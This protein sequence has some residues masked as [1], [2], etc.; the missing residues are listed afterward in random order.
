ML[1]VLGLGWITVHA[2]PLVRNGIV[3]IVND[4]IITFQELDGFTSQ[5]VAVLQRSFRNQPSVY[6]ERYAET[7][8]D[9]LDQ[10]IQRE[11]ILADF[12]KS[13]GTLNESYIDDEI[14]DRIR[15]QYGDRATLTK[16]LQQRG[17]TF[18]AFQTR[19]HKK[20]IIRFMRRM[21]V[22]SAIVVSP[23]K[24]ERYYTNH[25]GTFE[26][27]EQV[28]LRMLV[29]NRPSSAA[30]DPVRRRARQIRAKIEEGVPFAEMASVYSEG[31]ARQEGGNWD[32]VERSRLN[33]GLSEVAFGLEKGK[34]SPLLALAR[35]PNEDYWIYQ[36][37]ADG[38]LQ[39]GR[40][41]TGRDI[42]IEEK[43]F[44]GDEAPGEEALFPPQE[45]YLMLV[46]NRRE[47]RTRPLSEVREEIEK[48][49]EIEE[50]FRLE[51]KWIDKLAKQSFV[52]RY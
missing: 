36:Y 4:S 25:L 42:F 18:E 3:A 17:M 15:R 10:L 26:V 40:K 46:E 24:I 21:N 47:A 37:D 50:Q 29:L 39:K 2:Q 35:E 27:G 13:G 14:K 45:F 43:E 38:R 6:Q 19:T 22:S 16:T 51:K 28:K 52:I 12:E 48:E 5:A 49:L 23:A 34:V 8:K 41:Y 32:W 11:L 30:I 9:G 7:I 33:A 31:S 44:V 20:I 1:T